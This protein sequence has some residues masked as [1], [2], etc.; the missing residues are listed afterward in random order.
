L[1]LP[2]LGAVSLV[3]AVAL[4]VVLWRKP[5]IEAAL[6]QGIV[7]FGFP[8]ARWQSLSVGLKAAQITGLSLAPGLG[9]DQIELRFRLWPIDD[10]VVE[11][12][13]IIGLALDARD[14]ALAK[15]L[16]AVTRQEASDEPRPPL[17]VIALNRGRI[18]YGTPFGLAEATLD[19]A[20]R[21]QRRGDAQVTAEL[22][23]R[24]ADRPARASLTMRLPFDASKPS[25]GRVVASWGQEPES[26]WRLASDFAIGP[27][28]DPA[29]ARLGSF[30]LLLPGYGELMAD[31]VEMQLAGL[32]QPTQGLLLYAP[33]VLHREATPWHGPLAVNAALTL[34][35]EQLRFDADVTALGGARLT[36]AGQ[37]DLA[38]WVG[39]MNWKLGGL[40]FGSPGHTVFDLSPRFGA[41]LTADGLLEADGDLTWYAGE[42]RARA[43][44]SAGALSLRGRDWSLDGLEGTVAVGWSGAGVITP[45]RQRI[46][47]KGLHLPSAF[48]ERPWIEFDLRDRPPQ[49]DIVRAEAHVFDGEVA[50]TGS[51]LAVGGGGMGVLQAS[52][53][54]LRRLLLPLEIDGLSGE[55]RLS[56]SLPLR[57]QA[58]ALA[59][60]G[61]H[62]ASVE[63]GY[64][65]LVSPEAESLLEPDG[66]S[67]EQVL[68]ALTDFRYRQLTARLDR[69]LAGETRLHVAMRGANPAMRGGQPLDVN[70]NLSANFDRLLL[71]LQAA[72]RAADAELSARLNRQ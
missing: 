42:L 69:S 49:L 9:V 15:L 58:G 44:I 20:V 17:P 38:R 54:S 53:L 19:A 8:D 12:I 25:E 4:A 59:I 40:E 71:P 50:L 18:R 6:R 26:S 7:D 2:I 30:G 34:A 33:V 31:S 1:L 28:R 68:R 36:L 13:D 14:P 5:A 67:S 70:L 57:Y 11:H 47:A 48:L 32:A 65:R 41:E 66:A 37:H 60:D 24:L 21:R 10:P 56:G 23:T 61:G 29:I 45:G 62:L 46:G 63:P 43:T 55:G 3:A 51:Q 22:A 52:N 35:G 39:R 16:A 72:L 64:F 27:E